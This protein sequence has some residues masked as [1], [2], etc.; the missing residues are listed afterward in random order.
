[1]LTA[2][3]T[4]PW[5]LG[6]SSAAFLLMDL[7]CQSRGSYWISWVSPQLT[8]Q[9][10]LARLRPSNDLGGAASSAQV[11]KGWAVWLS[12]LHLQHPAVRGLI[13]QPQCYGSSTL[14]LY[15]SWKIQYLSVFSRET[16]SFFFIQPFRNKVRVLFRGMSYVRKY[17]CF[18]S[19][20]FQKTSVPKSI[21]IQWHIGTIFP[22][23]KWTKLQEKIYQ[24]ELLHLRKKIFKR[25]N[26]TL[27]WQDKMNYLPWN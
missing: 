24:I 10:Q 15:F 3:L 27:R 26:E 7:G 2:L 6:L 25:E 16:K 4:C 12:Q 11:E 5:H 14:Q 8:L 17:G 13:K 19:R 9:V 18:L 23:V 20:D 21:E 1:M 22:R